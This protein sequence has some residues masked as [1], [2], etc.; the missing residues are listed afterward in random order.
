LNAE[1]SGKILDFGV[2]SNLVLKGV[3][4]TRHVDLVVTHADFNATY[5]GYG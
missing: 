1:N 4:E 5:Y 3:A 2:A